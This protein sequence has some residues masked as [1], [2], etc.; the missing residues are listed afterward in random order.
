MGNLESNAKRRSMMNI[1]PMGNS[2]NSLKALKAEAIGS[3]IKHKS[4]KGAFAAR[5]RVS[6]QAVWRT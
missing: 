2:Q 1:T 6:K 4:A 5:T 3:N